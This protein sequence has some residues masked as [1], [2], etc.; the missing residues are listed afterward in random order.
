[1]LW[2]AGWAARALA[3]EDDAPSAPPERIAVI[4]EINGPIGPAVASYFITQLETASENGA[5]LVIAE[6]DTPGGLLWHNT[7][8]FS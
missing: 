8:V 4:L 2:L 7:R 6:M 1:M 3:Q 5:E